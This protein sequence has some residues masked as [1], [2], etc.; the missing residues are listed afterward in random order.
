MGGWPTVEICQGIGPPAR[1]RIPLAGGCSQERKRTEMT[2]K[3]TELILYFAVMGFGGWV[4]ETFVM[5]IWEGK[6]D[7]RGFLNGPTLPIYAM[8]GLLIRLIFGVLM[9]G[10][11]ML[12]VFFIGMLGSAVLEF[13]T[14]Y[15]LEKI[16]HQVW[17]DYSVCPLNVQGRICPPATFGF[18]VA[19]MIVV[20]IIN[21]RLCGL[22]DR[23]PSKLAMGLSA[24]YALFFVADLVVTVYNLKFGSLR[25]PGKE[26][27]DR[28]MESF[29]DGH[30]L[31][32]KSISQYVHERAGK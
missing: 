27:F 30:R 31:T 12:Q 25:V 23:M 21:P 29:V 9:P 26:G 3:L 10:H 7:N 2:E 22:I 15:V 8:G 1:R 5:T 16:F 6:W 24:L 20:Y 4:Y 13:V 18:G 11:T 17:W 19:A 28:R 14:S 32:E